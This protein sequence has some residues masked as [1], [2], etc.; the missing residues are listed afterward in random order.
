MPL[1]ECHSTRYLHRQLL[2]SSP[3]ITAIAQLIDRL[4]CAYSAP[5][6]L[7]LV[8]ERVAA[9]IYSDKQSTAPSYPSLIL[10]FTHVCLPF[11][12]G[13]IG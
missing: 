13:I 7:S 2:L 5:S 9:S 6:G 12:S 1:R 4:V 3:K 8:N 10:H 11:Y